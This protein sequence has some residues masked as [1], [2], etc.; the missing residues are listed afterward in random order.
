[1]EKEIVS[2]SVSIPDRIV[3]GDTEN[4]QGLVV[5]VED[6]VII[7]KIISA[8]RGKSMVRVAEHQ[9]NR[10]I[11]TGYTMNIRFDFKSKHLFGEL[12]IGG[13]SDVG[14]GFLLERAED[15]NWFHGAWDPW[16][17]K[18]YWINV[19]PYK[20]LTHPPSNTKDQWAYEIFS[21]LFFTS[22]DFIKGVNLHVSPDGI[23]YSI[24]NPYLK[25]NEVVEDLLRVGN[26]RD[27]F[28][29]HPELKV[30]YVS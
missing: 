12:Q 21:F 18:A 4:P 17:L 11:E 28:Y 6:P 5:Y 22:Q 20:W 7:K 24:Q 15:Y 8:F 10:P 1:M 29:I 25:H 27:F 26:I 2:Q 30:G 13:K 3:F 14:F 9:K 16:P 19:F 23:R